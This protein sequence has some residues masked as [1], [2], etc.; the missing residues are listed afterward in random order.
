MRVAPWPRYDAIRHHNLA[1][2]ARNR[3]RK[4]QWTKL[5]T[6]FQI[7]IGCVVIFHLDRNIWDEHGG[8][9]SGE[10]MLAPR[11]LSHADC[12]GQRQTSAWRISTVT[13]RGRPAASTSEDDHGIFGEQ[14]AYEYWCARRGERQT[15]TRCLERAAGTGGDPRRWMIRVQD[16]IPSSPPRRRP[17]GGRWLAAGE[18]LGYAAR[19]WD[20]PALAAPASSRPPPASELAKLARGTV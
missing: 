11:Q 1:P 9:G 4:I 2:G 16:A 15:V 10:S 5:V 13:D 7:S 17:G 14:S 19:N 12:E 20:H 3:D 8:I 18:E 6:S